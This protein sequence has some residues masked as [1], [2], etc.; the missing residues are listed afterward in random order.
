MEIDDSRGALR[1]MAVITFMTFAAR[2]LAIPF[3]GLYLKSV[4]FQATEIGF[5][6]SLSALV[7][8]VVT[9]ALNSL[10][11]QTGTHRVLYTRLLAGNALAGIGMV[12]F[13]ANRFLLGGAVILRESTDTP[14]AALLSQL[15]ITWLDE[16]KRAIYGRLRAWGSLGWAV[17]TLVSGRIYAL[18][19]YPLLF[20]LFSAFN[21]AL[22]PLVKVLPERTAN[23][24][25]YDGPLPPRS[26]TFYMLM[27]SL[28]LFAVGNNA[29]STFSFIYFRENLGASNELIGIIS[30]VAAL[31]EIP[32]MV[33][34]DRLLRRTNTRTTLII[35]ML[36]QAVLW[37]GFTLL[38]QATFLIPLMVF[39]GT[40]FTFFNVSMALLVSRVSHPAN[41]ATNQALAQVTVPGLAVLLAGWVNGWLFDNAGPDTLFRFAAFTAI[42][43]AVVLLW[44]RGRIAAQE[45]A[46]GELRAVTTTSS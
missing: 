17:T 37:I 19:G 16:R 10:A 23:R 42:L 45:Q 1:R 26:L 4:G 14:S 34:I 7:Q 32:S 29:Y 36:G 30:S 6:T 18:G 43:A 22:M 33:L 9:P 21:L 35:G 15:T 20:L 39:R 12:V 40:F 5:I 28:F 3:V 38:T 8:L 31:S 2:G 44:A 13:T 24:Q 27:A 11:D 46:M 41:A 25:A